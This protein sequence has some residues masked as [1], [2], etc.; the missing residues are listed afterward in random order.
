MTYLDY[1]WKVPV[2]DS[3]NLAQI[4]RVFRPKEVLTLLDNMD[5]KDEKGK[6]SRTWLLNNDLTTDDVREWLK[7]LLY[8]GCRFSEAVLIHDNPSLLRKNGTIFL[9]NIEEGKKK[10][11]NKSRVIYLSEWGKNN[12]Q[13][14]FSAKPLPTIN[15][16]EVNQTLISLTLIMH[17]AG[18]RIGLQEETFGISR[19]KWLKDE[20][21]EYIK[22]VR[23]RLKEQI[24]LLH[25]DSS[26]SRELF[27]KQKMLEGE[28][29]E[30]ITIKS[31]LTTNGCTVRS[32][33]KTWES[34]L[35]TYYSGNNTM[36]DLILQSQNHEEGTSRR[37]YAHFDFN[38]EEDKK[39][40]EELIRG[41]GEV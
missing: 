8:M 17:S 12:I 37:D 2:W 39:D 22:D 38:N 30:Y 21:G 35:L 6:N 5:I 4:I 16:K 40:I 33:R 25:P 28:G 36:R 32:M 23:R 19:K 18:K 27:H 3:D 7:G 9:R 13:R 41:Y 34:W 10:R 24:K 20:N 26:E 1:E 29:K 14:F 31:K 15:D 11:K